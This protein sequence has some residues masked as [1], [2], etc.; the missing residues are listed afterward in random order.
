MK[1]VLAWHFVGLDRRLR[2]GSEKERLIVA[3]GYVYTESAPIVICRSGLHASTR[4]YDALR[5]APG[6]VICRVRMWG[7]VVE[8]DDKLVARNREV[9]WMAD[10]TSEVRLWAAW[11]VRQVWHL[12]TDQRSRTAVEVAE[13]FARGE[14]PREELAAVERAAWAAERA[15]WAA[16]RAARGSAERA[17]RA[18]ERA[19]WA[20]AR[21]ARDSQIAEFE[22]RMLSLKPKILGGG[23]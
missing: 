22:R 3:P 15:A 13:R 6:L 9:L 14:A 5:Y 19:A 23:Q 18:A 16:E 4:A 7:D 10:A 17:E 12:L 20:A 2:Y 8:G 11:C 21:G 1:N